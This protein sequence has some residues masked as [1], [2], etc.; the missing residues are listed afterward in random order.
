[1]RTSGLV[2]HSFSRVEWPETVRPTTL[3]QLEFILENWSLFLMN[4][5]EVEL[6]CQISPDDG[7]GVQTP[8]CPVDTHRARVPSERTITNQLMTSSPRRRRSTSSVAE[9]INFR[10]QWLHAASRPRSQMGSCAWCRCSRT[11]FP[12]VSGEAA[13]LANMW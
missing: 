7:S 8:A 4:Q 6:E 1:M 10:G 13:K 2:Q 9:I 5:P 3:T 11:V 12:E